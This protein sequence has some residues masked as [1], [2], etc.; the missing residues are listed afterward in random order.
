[1]ENTSI[2]NKTD[3]AS[4]LVSAITVVGAQLRGFRIIGGGNW[5]TFAPTFRECLTSHVLPHI[6]WL[7]LYDVFYF[8]LIDV[9]GYGKH[10]L[11]FDIGA[12]YGGISYEVPTTSDT[13]KI[14]RLPRITSFSLSEFEDCDLLDDMTVGQ[15]LDLAGGSITFWHVGG[16]YCRDF[17]LD[18]DF[19]PSMNALRVNLQHL[20]FGHEV[21]SSV[22]ID[23][24]EQPELRYLL[25][26][27]TFPNLTTLTFWMCL[28]SP[29]TSDQWSHWF[30][31]MARNLSQEAPAS[32]TN[33]H[34]DIGWLDYPPSIPP[35][36]PDPDFSALASKSKVK[37]RCTV[38]R[39]HGDTATRVNE[40]VDL[41]RVCLKAWEEEKRMEIWFSDSP[42]MPGTV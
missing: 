3:A 7:E 22:V 14:S 6:L 8:P 16:H 39:R 33:L 12:R 24:H 20:S 1:M 29:V 15:Y 5:T 38:H 13:A 10:L 30:A 19:L 4:E 28:P 21:Y 37:I 41:F 25:P 40:T 27:S 23:Y 35:Q 17:P 32:L 42:D 34:F 36:V 31:Y 26:L 2:L 18:L 9:L 11:S